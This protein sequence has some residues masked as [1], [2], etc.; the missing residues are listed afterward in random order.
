MIFIKKA[1]DLTFVLLN[2]A[3]EE[4]LG[5]TEA[6]ILGK[7]DYD[8]F[9]KDQADFFTAK[10]REV[11]LKGGLTD[12]EEEPISTPNGIRWLHTKKIPLLGRDGTPLFLVGI[13]EDITEKKRIETSL[14]LIQNE[15]EERVV[16][17]TRELEEEKSRLQ[18]TLRSMRE[19]VIVTDGS[20]KIIL[21]NGLVEEITGWSEEESV[22]ALLDQILRVSHPTELIDPFL[23]RPI[24]DLGE[25][26]REEVSSF[27]RMARSVRY[28]FRSR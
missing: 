24:A 5:V 1:D 12:I 9:P 22:G 18:G 20:K 28:S 26:S 10:D 11:L 6:G 13:S 7:S 21:V 14:Q 3:G 25:L 19:G 17:R 16:S 8:F 23:V 27:A 2:R 4:L 15:L